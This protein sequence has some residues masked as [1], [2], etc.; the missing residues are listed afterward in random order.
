MAINVSTSDLYSKSIDAKRIANNLDSVLTSVNRVKSSLSYDILNASS[1]SSSINSIL[2]DILEQQNNMERI[3]NFL[4]K[5]SQDY[6]NSELLLMALLGNHMEETASSDFLPQIISSVGILGGGYSLVSGGYT[7]ISVLA[8]GEAFSSSEKKMNLGKTVLT[9]VDKGLNADFSI[10]ASFS[11][12][13]VFNERSYTANF[14][15]SLF[16]SIAKG[17]KDVVCSTLDF[18]FDLVDSYS[19]NI[20]EHSSLLSNYGRGAREM[21]LEAGI[22]YVIGGAV[23]ASIKTLGAFA[24]G[25]NPAGWAVVG[26]AAVAVT[27]SA[28]A[29][30]YLDSELEL[31]LVIEGISDFVNDTGE[32]AVK[33]AYNVG[34][35]AVKAIGTVISTVADVAIAGVQGALDVGKSAV[36]AGGELIG[37]IASSVAET[38]VAV[39][40]E[41]LNTVADVGSAAVSAVKDVGSAAVST[42]SAMASTAKSAVS[43]GANKA[44]EGISSA[45]NKLSFF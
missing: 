37:D 28:F 2:L 18:G 30:H 14:M 42:A 26:I 32:A 27:A 34:S 7:L 39:G 41:V 9:I 19:K 36:V 1:V 12:K 40:K 21:F 20:V 23:S 33:F 38:T 6:E 15:D 11:L 45:W 16:P 24:L 13:S 8:S 29:T 31:E 43:T 44:I 10:N 3:E 5:A 22:N 35:A 25:S 4:L 17:G